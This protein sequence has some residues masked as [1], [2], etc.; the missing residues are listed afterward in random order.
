[1]I[2]TLLALL[3]FFSL[4]GIF[5]TQYVP[6][7]M[8]DNEATLTA[9]ASASFAQFKSSVD[10]QYALDGPQTYGTPFTL[11]SQG[12][13]LIAQPTEGTLTFIPTTCPS[14]FL[15]PS[16]GGVAGDYG[17]P[18]NANYCVYLNVTESY[19]PG[20]ST[21]YAQAIQ[22]GILELSLPNRYY[23]PET[24]YFENDA[25]IQSQSTGYQIMA[26]PPPLNIS[27]TPA[28]TSVSG[29]I[30]QLFGNASTV[31]GQGSEDVYSNLRYSQTVASNGKLVAGV[32]EPLVFTFTVGTQYPC[33]WDPYLYNLVTTSGMPAA[34]YALSTNVN[35]TPTTA[36]TPTYTGSCFN[37]DGV[38]TQLSFELK[39][40]NYATLYLAGVQVGIGL[41]GS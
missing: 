20:G 11:S 4:F 15:T 34:D 37:V 13:P 19:G 38:T 14:G 16:N 35:G 32:Q 2:G 23:T 17:L 3:V 33:A 1:M 6:L 10:Q 31:V 40:A 24:F 12:V 8:T 18:R 39:F 5:L 28:N 7:W 41:G 26:V 21:N 22:A 25:V 30:L 27:Y 36:L 29:S 9:Q